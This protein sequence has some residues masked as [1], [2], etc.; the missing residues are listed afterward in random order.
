MNQALLLGLL[1]TLALTG[2]QSAGIRGDLAAVG[3]PV[4]RQI[5][6]DSAAYLKDHYAVGTTVFHLANGEQ[7]PVRSAV[8]Q[9]LRT[10]G[11][12]VLET[13]EAK[14]PVPDSARP[15]V[16]SSAETPEAVVVTLGLDGELL[17]RAYDTASGAPVS[18]WTRRL[19]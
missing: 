4:A 19:P 13:F 1:L 18:A 16:V 15:L 11:F 14:A 2:C 8:A 12:E 6:E 5:G 17:S 9:A 10:A 7:T 3:E